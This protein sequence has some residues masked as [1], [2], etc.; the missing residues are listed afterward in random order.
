MWKVITISLPAGNGRINW[1]RLGFRQFH[2][3][4]LLWVKSRTI[5]IFK[6]DVGL[7][8]KKTTMCNWNCYF[9]P[10]HSISFIFKVFKIHM[11]TCWFSSYRFHCKLPSTVWWGKC[12]DPPHMDLLNS[13]RGSWI[14]EGE[15]WDTIN[16]LESHTEDQTELKCEFSY[17]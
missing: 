17:K 4:S 1:Y 2:E 8:G 6:R 11:L 16:A 13:V 12:I 7:R 5:D 15:K 3:S 9:F 10:H 14:Q